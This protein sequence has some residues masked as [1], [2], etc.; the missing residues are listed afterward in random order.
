M[1][2]ILI[3]LVTVVAA[4]WFLPATTV[5]AEMVVVV[6]PDNPI[7]TIDQQQLVD[8]YTG[9]EMNFPD[10]SYAIPFDLPPD[11]S[12]RQTFY[13]TLL[14]KTVAQV[15]AYWARLL[16]TGRATPP[17]VLPSAESVIKMIQDNKAA[18]AYLD[19][20]ETVPGIKVIFR[21][22]PPQ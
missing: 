17:R 10:G 21:L 2:R 12:Q 6:H 1:K 22:A 15:N 4:W 14:G 3:I 18:I 19:S 20:S 16:F 7:A 11:S 13:K 5:L 9:R 8:I